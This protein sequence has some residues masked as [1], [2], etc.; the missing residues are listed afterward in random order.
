MFFA[1]GMTVTISHRIMTPDG[2]Y[3]VTDSYRLAGCA[4]S[5]TSKVRGVYQTQTFEEDRVRI[6]SF[7]FAPTGSDVR[8][9]DTITLDDGTLWH[10]WGDPT[11]FVSAFTGWQP[12]MQIPLR[13]FSG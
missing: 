6:L 13:H 12:G 3:Q 2:D 1:H 4:L 11:G 9:S 10:V 8:R 5:L 7:L